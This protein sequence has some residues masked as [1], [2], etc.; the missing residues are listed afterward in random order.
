MGRTPAS[1]SK[2]RAASPW[3]RPCQASPE[4]RSV[5]T[6]CECPPTEP[7]ERC[8]SSPPSTAARWPVRCARKGNLRSSRR[9]ES[10]NRFGDRCRMVIARGLASRNPEGAEQLA[11]QIEFA[12]L[13]YHCFLPSLVSCPACMPWHGHVVPRTT[14]WSSRTGRLPVCHWGNSSR[15][16]S[17][18]RS[19]VRHSKAELRWRCRSFKGRC[20]IATAQQTTRA[21]SLTDYALRSKTTMNEAAVNRRVTDPITRT[22]PVQSGQGLANAA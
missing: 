9:P 16:R 7:P 15:S 4:A 13:R 5:R 22:R 3:N 2:T 6:P 12:H 18:L 10:L 1:H 17:R 19:A 8:A 20:A 21:V 11:D 14:R